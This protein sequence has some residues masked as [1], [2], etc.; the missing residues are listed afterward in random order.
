M[1][2]KMAKNSRERFGK[3]TIGKYID[4]DGNYITDGAC[5][6][7][8]EALEITK[9]AAS[10]WFVSFRNDEED[11]PIS[12]IYLRALEHHTR[13]GLAWRKPLGRKKNITELLPKSAVGFMV[14]WNSKAIDADGN[15]MAGKYGVYDRSDYEGPGSKT[16]R[17]QHLVQRWT[18]I[19]P[20]PMD[21]EMEALNEYFANQDA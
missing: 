9:A 19:I 10:L 12:E 15:S 11:I 4:H 20:P 14:W 21:A 13:G 1:A 3:A 8:A 18:P 16:F 6:K 17:L 5:K 7:L 2:A